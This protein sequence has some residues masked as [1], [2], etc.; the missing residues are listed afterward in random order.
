MFTSRDS[1][2]AIVPMFHVCAWGFPYVAPLVGAK[3]VFPGP[4][5]D[6]AS[7]YQLFEAEAVTVSAG[8]PT[9]WLGL[10]DHLRETGNRLSHLKYALS[11]GASPPR[12]MIREIEEMGIRFIQGWGMTETSPVAARHRRSART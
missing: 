11:G 9:V 6:G 7:L 5:Y 3:L 1:F 10:L 8:V 12:A 2:L 4:A